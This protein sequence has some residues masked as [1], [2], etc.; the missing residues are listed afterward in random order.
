MMNKIKTFLT[1]LI[2][3]LTLIACNDNTIAIKD[4]RMALPEVDKELRINYEINESI[5]FIAKEITNSDEISTCEH[6]KKLINSGVEIL[7]YLK[8]KFSDSTET[9]VYSYYNKRNLTC[10]EIA[11]IVASEIKSI[12]IAYVVGIQ[13]C[14][15]PFDMEIEHY[16]G[17]IKSNPSE[18]NKKYNKWLKEEM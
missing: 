4:G 9:N 10:G 14:T 1:I 3:L 2:G 11:I 8:E 15:P 7:P 6:G 18:F 16:L 17:R 5:N 13:Q 12:P